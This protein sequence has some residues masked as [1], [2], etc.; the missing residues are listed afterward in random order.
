MFQTPELIMMAVSASR[1]YRSLADY[2]SMTEFNWSAEK[3]W[4][5]PRR[6]VSTTVPATIRFRETTQLS[7]HTERVTQTSR[8]E[9]DTIEGSLDKTVGKLASFTSTE[10]LFVFPSFP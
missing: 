5:A 9:A 3:S 2:T 1:I 6:A 10:P 4:A 8:T 7:Q